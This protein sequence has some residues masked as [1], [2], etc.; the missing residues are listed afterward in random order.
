M[1]AEDDTKP[2]GHERP[3]NDVPDPDFDVSEGD[4]LSPLPPS[5]PP[6]LHARLVLALKTT[7]PDVLAAAV[8]GFRGV[9]ASCH[10]ATEQGRTRY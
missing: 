9:F 10:H 7:A 4:E 2:P 1:N 5:A 6:D 3:S 8:D